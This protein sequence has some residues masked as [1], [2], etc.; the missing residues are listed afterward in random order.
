V[1]S[2]VSRGRG[3]R[4]THPI[5]PVNPVRSPVISVPVAASPAVWGRALR[6]LRA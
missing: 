2:I 1:W 3:V 5:H 4:E 6:V